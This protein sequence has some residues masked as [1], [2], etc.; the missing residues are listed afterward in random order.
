MTGHRPPFLAMVDPLSARTILQVAE[1]ELEAIARRAVAYEGTP[2]VAE[3]GRLLQLVLARLRESVR[4]W[5]E[6]Q[7]E[8]TVD[9]P[10]LVDDAETWLSTG[11][12]AKALEVSTRQ[13]GNY[14][15]GGDGPLSA[16]LVKGAWRIR[17]DDLEDFRRWR[18]E[19]A[20]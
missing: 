10:D 15:H 9:A 1:K 13:V 20:G 11:D 6:A 4:Q 16:V 8:L 2:Q 17:A 7:A 19:A 18:A 14:I 12:V 3:Q 5:R